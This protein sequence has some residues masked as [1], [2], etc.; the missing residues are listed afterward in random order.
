MNIL[1]IAHRIPYPPNKGDKIRSFHQIRYLASKHSVSLACLIDDREDLRYIKT[2]GQYCTSVDAI[3]RDKNLATLLSVP[4]L[5]KRKPISVAFFYSRELQKKI[6]A[7]VRR[8]KFDRIVVFCSAMA[9]Y[10]RQL[11]GIPKIMDFVDVDSEKWRVYADHQPVS[12]SWIYRMEADRLA[13]YEEAVAQDFDQSIFVSEKEADIFRRR[14]NDDRIT[15]NSN[16]VDLE[17]FAPR[18]SDRVNSGSPVIVFSGTMDYFPNIDAVRY[19]CSDIF[20]LIRNVF[21]TVQFYIA[22]RN[23]PRKVV[24]LNGQLGVTV[25]GGVPDVRPFLEKAWVSV[26]PLRIARGVQNK[27]LESMAMGLPVVGTSRAFQ[28]LEATS[29][30]GIRLADS[31]EIFAREVTALLEN[32]NARGRRDSTCSV[33][34]VGRIMVG[35]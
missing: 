35:A 34:I 18:G 6:L 8:E 17:Y 14:I 31:P 4:G 5:L 10:V 15:V 7:R 33:I 27:V 13:R 24:E 26:A 3:Y 20:P 1:Y 23:P 30:D 32:A 11:A 2:L 19:F 22:G 28:G 21:P 29:G 12:V 25:T 9:E 16:G